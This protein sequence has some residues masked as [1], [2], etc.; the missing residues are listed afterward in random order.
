MMALDDIRVLE[1]ARTPVASFATMMLADFGADVLKLELPPKAGMEVY[2]TPAGEENRWEAAHSPF[3]RNKRNMVLNLKSPEGLEIVFK[4]AETADVI[5]EG[6]RPGYVRQLGIDFDSLFKINPRLVYCSV[7]SYGQDGPY[8]GIPGHNVNHIA[9][10]GI[11]GLVGKRDGPP[12]IPLNIIGD[13][14]AGGMHCANGILL[15]LMARHRTGRGQYIDLSITDACVSLARMFA[16]SYFTS[17]SVPRRGYD[18]TGGALPHYNVYETRDGQYISVGCV[19]PWFWERLCEILERPE[20]KEYSFR[21]EYLQRIKGG[22][23][24]LERVQQAIQDAFM[25]RT[26]AEWI[27]LMDGEKLPVTKVYGIDEVFNDP[28]VL[29][30]GMLVELG[31]PDADKIRQV[32]I[33]I[34]LSETPGSVRSAGPLLGEHTDLVLDELGYDTGMIA[35][36]RKEGVIA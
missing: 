5:V 30:R 6:F 19:E 25:T 12:I 24:E 16:A 11:L 26:C 8:T 27:E 4:L 13:W 10:A 33:P 21:P 34:K 9:L 3:N 28:Q 15:A 18:M 7:S 31:A 1:F 22:D 35:E 36:L 23:E 29:H 32:G 2:G 20:L 14:A 17:G